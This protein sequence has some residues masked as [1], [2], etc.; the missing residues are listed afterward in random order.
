VRTKVE[1]GLE[2]TINLSGFGQT[3]IGDDTFPAL[4]YPEV[5]KRGFGMKGRQHK[6]NDELHAHAQLNSMPRV[7]FQVKKKGR[8][9]VKIGKQHL[10]HYLALRDNYK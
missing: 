2:K 8:P 10:I 5:M 3:I 9:P 4:Y 6:H 1:S 7:A